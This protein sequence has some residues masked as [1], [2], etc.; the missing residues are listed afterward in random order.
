M[1]L[2]IIVPIYNVEKY[3]R[4]CIESIFRQGLDE[5]RFEVIIVN[6]GTQ[7]K[8]MEV[9]A[10][11]IVR[12]KN[13]IVINQENQG[14]SV[15]RNNGIAVAKGEYLLMPDSDDMLIDHS[16][17]PLLEKAL[18]EKSRYDC[19]RLYTDERRRNK[20]SGPTSHQ[21]TKR[22]SSHRN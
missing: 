16:V 13:I 19:G 4:T 2:S 21:S 12:H 17:E 3:V 1:D 18:A 5:N 11:I 7:D 6:D 15:A 8:S 10:D 14:L 9:I 20:Q 22:V